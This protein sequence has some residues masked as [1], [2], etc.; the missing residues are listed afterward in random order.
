MSKLPSIG[1]I[2]AGQIGAA[3]ARALARRN[4][5]AILANSRGPE[6]L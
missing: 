1:I 5:P 2:D 4:I 3:F 6:S